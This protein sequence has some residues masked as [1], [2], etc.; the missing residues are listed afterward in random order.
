MS[1]KYWAHAPRACAPQQKKPPQSEAHTP[2]WRVAPISHNKD[3]AQPKINNF[4]KILKKSCLLSFWEFSLPPSQ[5]W[6]RSRVC[7]CMCA[8][9]CPTL[10]NPLNC[11]P[12]GSSVHGIFQ[13]RIL[14]WVAIASSRG[15]SLPW[16]Q[17]QVSCS[18]CIASGFFTTEPPGKHQDHEYYQWQKKRGGG[19]REGV[20]EWEAGEE[21]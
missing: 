6:L 18:S 4:L 17:T 8:Q 14:E 19:R 1:C 16:N 12:P 3:P 11:S 10:C 9:L 20:G 13:A 2:Q 7:L 21:G 5:P 15:S